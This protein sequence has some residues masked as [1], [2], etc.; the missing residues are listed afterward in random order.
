[1]LLFDWATA[2]DGTKNTAIKQDTSR[3]NNGR[4]DTK[5]D[6]REDLVVGFIRLFPFGRI[7]NREAAFA[8]N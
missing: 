4:Q 8:N 7:L 6:A 2:V 1:G 5:I 3:T